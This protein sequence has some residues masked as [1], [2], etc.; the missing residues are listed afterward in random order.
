MK[1]RQSISIQGLEELLNFA[2]G[3][4][5][6]ANVPEPGRGYESGHLKRYLCTHKIHLPEL[7]PAMF[8][9]PLPADFVV[10]YMWNALT[11]RELLAEPALEDCDALSVHGWMLAPE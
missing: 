4:L 2:F 1:G 9:P 11:L 3:M 6:A 8:Q 5:R 10:T 7:F